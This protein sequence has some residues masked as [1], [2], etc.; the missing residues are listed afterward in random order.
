MFEWL[1]GIDRELFY[2]F[3]VTLANPVTDLIMPFLTSN[4]VLRT[5]YALA[6]ILMFWKGDRKLCWLALF[7]GLVVLISDQLVSS[8]LKEIIDRPRPCHSGQ[9]TD[10]RLLVP[11]GAGKSMPSA[12]AANAFGLAVFFSWYYRRL[13]WYL[14]VFAALVALSR[15]CVGVHYPGDIA[16][17][18]LI[19]GSVGLQWSICITGCLE[20]DA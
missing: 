17:G 1:G 9:L 19:G 5:L 3:N 15:V 10:I 20:M 4:N 2:F 16:A 14:L 12:H 6:L 11:C 13:L 7:S 8:V 18:G